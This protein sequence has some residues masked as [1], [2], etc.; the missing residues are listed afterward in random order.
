[1]NRASLRLSQVDKR[2][3]WVEISTRGFEEKNIGRRDNR[4]VFGL[5]KRKR[6]LVQDNFSS[7]EF[8][9]SFFAIHGIEFMKRGRDMLEF[10]EPRAVTIPEP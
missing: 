9:T 5:I 4:F 8:S 2:N 10:R 3:E 1:M 6:Y 7:T